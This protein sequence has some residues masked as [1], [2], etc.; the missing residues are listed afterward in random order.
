M[1]T[2]ARHMYALLQ[3]HLSCYNFLSHEKKLHVHCVLYISLLFSM[4]SIISESCRLFDC[5]SELSCFLLS[6][7]Y[8]KILRRKNKLLFKCRFFCGEKWERVTMSLVRHQHHFNSLQNIQLFIH[9]VF[10]N[11]ISWL[12]GSEYCTD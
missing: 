3:G 7:F 4:F 12:N 2:V 8:V 9:F 11:I 1:M 10:P 6:R 5:I